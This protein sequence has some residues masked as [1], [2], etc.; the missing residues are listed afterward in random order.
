MQYSHTLLFPQLS[1]SMLSP[2]SVFVFKVSGTQSDATSYHPEQDI[3]ESHNYYSLAIHNYLVYKRTS[4]VVSL[5]G[6]ANTNTLLG[7]TRVHV[8]T[9]IM[10]NRTARVANRSSCAVAHRLRN[11]GAKF[12]CQSLVLTI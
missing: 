11:V 5:D 2:S 4:E 6:T 8:Q 7:L 3:I 10:C 12:I 1:G 9:V